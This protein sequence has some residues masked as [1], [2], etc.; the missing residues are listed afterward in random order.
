MLVEG[1]QIL[2]AVLIANEVV[3][4]LPRRKERGLL[5]K[6]TLRRCIITWIGIFYSV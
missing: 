3:D 4:A 2:D 6:L 5:C 1:R